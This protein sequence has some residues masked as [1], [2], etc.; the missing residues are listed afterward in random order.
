MSLAPESVEQKLREPLPGVA[1]ER[2]QGEAVRDFHALL[3]PSSF[4]KSARTCEM[5][6]SA[7]S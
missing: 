6:R 2:Q 3:R 7:S 5:N 4:W 1:F